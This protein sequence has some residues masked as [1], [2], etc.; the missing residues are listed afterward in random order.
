[1]KHCLVRFGLAALAS[2]AAHAQGAS[3]VAESVRKAIEHNPQVAASFDALHAARDEADAAAGAWY[4]RVNAFADAGH[5]TYGYSGPLQSSADFAQ[6][7]VRLELR[8]LLWDGLATN[9]EIER[10]GHAK[11][12]RYFEFLDATEQV[13]LD[14]ARAWY[15]VVRERR[16][17]ALA[18]E[19][20]VQHKVTFDQ[21]QQRVKAGVGR[22]V[23]LEQVVAR[24]ALAQSG[25]VAERANL[26]DAIE[27]Y[28]AVVGT[29]PP[30][31]SGAAADALARPLPATQ[32]AALEEA[33]RRSPSVSAA[34]ENLRAAR[35]A[36]EGRK[37]AYQPRIEARVSA[38]DG[39]NIDG[40]LYENHDAG[41]QVV[42]TWNLFNGGSDAARE[43]Q[44]ASLLSQAQNLR[45]K[46]CLDMRQSV[47]T[48]FND[49][50]R[51]EEQLDVRRLEEQLGHLDRN[52]A[53]ITRA[54]DAYRQ[55]FEIGQRSLLDLL[56][57][58]N[59]LH[60]AR[61]SQ[62]QAEADL[63]TAVARTYAGMGTLLAALDLQRP[64]A[65]G[66]APEAGQWSEAGDAPARC[67]LQPVDV[68]GPTTAE[69]DARAQ[70]LEAARAA[71]APASGARPRP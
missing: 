16:F 21:V 48:A 6:N 10:L 60:G 39:H 42:L 58:E 47:A 64:D 11:L 20:Y 30:A 63:A 40:N 7:G 27:H 54:R 1:M 62:A 45:D 38:A 18:E 44:Y 67:P 17:V 8:Q 35:A 3:P 28:L 61:R 34:I 66:L 71:A 9:K 22:G 31:D 70:A 4:P 49:V 14:A 19:N 15:D 32:A 43:R 2:C 57:S 55:Q 51:L 25:L 56:N 59:E 29:L 26:H 68:G 53:S 46:A 37:G 23:D 13:G 69:L 50:R 24:V 41:A 65:G 12:L 52:V 36:A 5:R 33:A